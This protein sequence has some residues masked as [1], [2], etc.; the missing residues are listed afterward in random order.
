RY[1]LWVSSVVQP[2]SPEKACL[3]LLN[4]N[5][6]VSLSVILEY[7][8]SNTTIFDQ[9]VEAGNF[10]A[11]TNFKVSQTS[12]EQLAFVTLLAQGKT[13]KIS[14]RRV[15]AIAAEENETFVQT[16]TPIYKPGDTV[17]FRIVTLNTWLKPVD[18][19]YP[20]ITLQGKAQIRVCREFS[21]SGYCESDNNE[22]CEQ[23]TAQL[24]D[25]CIS[26]I[27]NTKV[28]QLY[29]SGFFMTFDVNVMVTEF[30][31]VLG[32]VSF[33]NMDS[34][35]RRGITYFGTLRFS[36]PDN[37]PMV[38]KL[39]QLELNG[40]F[41]GNYTTDGNGE[42]R[43]SINTSE[44]FDAQ[45]SLKAIY[46]RPETC[47]RPSWLDP[48]YLDAYF[49][50]SRFYSQT[51]SFLKIVPESK[52]LPCNQEKMVSVLYSLNPEAYKADSGV[53]FFYLVSLDWWTCLFST[54]QFRR[55]H[56]SGLV[57]PTWSG[58]FSFPISISADLAPAA[59]LFV[60][61]LH[62]GGEIVADSVQLQI[63]K[64]FKN[65]VSIKF[66][67]EHGLPG[68]TT[69]LRLQAAPDSFCALRAVDKSV[70]LLKPEQE[71]SPEI[72]KERKLTVRDAAVDSISHAEQ[73][74]KGTV[75]TH[76]PDTW[77]WDLISV[78]SSGSANV[79]FLVPDS[80]TQ[81]EA[82][83]FC[84]NGD[85]GFGISPKAYLQIF[86]PFFIE[87]ASPFSVV[88]NEQSDLVVTV[89]SHLTTC[90]EISV[91]LEASENYEANINT[92]STN[93][94]DVLQAGEQKTYVW[95]IIPKTLVCK[96]AVGCCCVRV[97]CEV[98]IRCSIVG[99]QLAVGTPPT[100]AAMAGVAGLVRK[101]REY[102]KTKEFRDYITSTHF[103]GPVANWGLPMAAFKDMK[104][105]PDII[106][107]RMTTAL[108]F[109]SMAF[110]RFAYRVQ[111]RNYLLLACH[112]SNVVAQSIQ[113][114]RY[115]K[116]HYV[117]GAK[118]SIPRAK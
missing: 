46:V 87:I 74:A 94:S 63:D 64:C 113:A 14:E 88:R 40:Q 30:G 51:N 17:H 33:E 9:S 95:T 57:N 83:A 27:V 13:L 39:L 60:Y 108:I 35:Y 52:Q 69:H 2:F 115:L 23:F 112:L 84:V 61:T 29:R 68:S 16:D 106:S 93:G 41:L 86:Q 73:A 70:L 20:S 8:G 44:I 48:E 72:L 25:G 75:R 1:I 26:Q 3:H 32:S 103:W 18:D 116:Y 76:F 11:C 77:I 22:I 42:A 92:R 111:P 81:W 82:S 118:A 91:Q 37:E 110:M 47:H 117:D 7:D 80:I 53:N 96:L 65:K 12:S 49:S 6:S 24:K 62:P 107:G 59:V 45:I 58:N 4:L 34:F 54:T 105:P 100:G 56:F 19:L 102:V 114:C 97:S 104:A 71:L 79:S 67:K 43:F 50:V 36:G 78:D 98:G 31:T 38:S 5:E 109:Y 10:Y 85:A 90:V 89:F 99:W 15:V 28:F 101:T 21:S 66:S 55:C